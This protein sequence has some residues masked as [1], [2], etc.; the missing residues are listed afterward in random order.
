MVKTIRITL[1]DSQHAELGVIKGKRTWYNVLLRGIESIENWSTEPEWA[2]AL[3]NKI[4]E[5]GKL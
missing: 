3:M 2:Q 5:R 1:N 4:D